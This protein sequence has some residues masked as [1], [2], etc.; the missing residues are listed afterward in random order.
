MN[1]FFDIL[2][3]SVL[4]AY[5]LFVWNHTNVFIEYY[6]ILNIKVLRAANS[7]IEQNKAG[8]IELYTEYLGKRDLFF[9][10]LFSCPTCLGFWLSLFSSVFIGLNFIY[11][12]YLSLIMYKIV[13]KLFQDEH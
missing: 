9:S 1:T 7:Y 4:V 12:C 10:K 11:V 6:K 3:F 2:F 13:E 5:I 8:F